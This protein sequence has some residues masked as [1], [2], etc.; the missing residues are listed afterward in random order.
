MKK[1]LLGLFAV[2]LAIGFSAFTAGKHN[3]KTGFSTYYAIKTS[4]THWKWST[5][6]PEGYTCQFESGA[7]TCSVVAPSQPA[8]DSAPGGTSNLFYKE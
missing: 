5:T 7:P 3:A 4:T 2:V 8:D 6:I 1:Y